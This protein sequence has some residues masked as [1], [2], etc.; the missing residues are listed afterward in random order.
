MFSKTRYLSSPRVVRVLL[1]K[2][3]HR[4]PKF[5]KMMKTSG[6]SLFLVLTL[7]ACQRKFQYLFAS[8][9]DPPRAVWSISS[10]FVLCFHSNSTLSPLLPPPKMA[11]ALRI[12]PEEKLGLLVL[13]WD[14]CWHRS[15]EGWGE[16]DRHWSCYGY[17]VTVE[18]MSP[19]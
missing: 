18:Q 2:S 15:W 17:W 12:R 11:V 8:V 10:I 16:C 1:L 4:F 3:W 19:T 7:P 13:Y 9:L 14:M 6:L 5:W